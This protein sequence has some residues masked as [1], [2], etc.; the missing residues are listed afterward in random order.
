VFVSNFSQQLCSSPFTVYK[1]QPGTF[2]ELQANETSGFASN[3]VLSEMTSNFGYERNPY[4][5]L[6]PTAPPLEGKP[7]HTQAMVRTN[8]IY[9]SQINAVQW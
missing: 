4:S 3:D 8:L 6:E 5:L 7:I 9:N 1:T 2:N